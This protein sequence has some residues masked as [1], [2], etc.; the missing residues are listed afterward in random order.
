MSEVILQTRL[1]KS[2]DL[3]SMIS[4][5]DN[6]V[7]RGMYEA[8]TVQTENGKQV[9]LEERACFLIVPD[10]RVEL[11]TFL[12][13]LALEYAQKELDAK[14]EDRTLA[15]QHSFLCNPVGGG[16]PRHIDFFAD[17][18]YPIHIVT[19]AYFNSDFDGGEL[20]FPDLEKSFK[21]E[22]GLVIAFDAKIPHMVTPLKSGRRYCLQRGHT[23][24]SA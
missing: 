4:F 17:M 5:I 18:Q 14:P 8:Q 2:I 6:K 23:L 7:E 9:I 1:D 11:T 16:V 3:Q 19:L 22:P 10:M 20:V 12:D 15:V 21:P 24:V 13:Q